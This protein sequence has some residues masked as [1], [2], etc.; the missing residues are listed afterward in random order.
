MEK[1]ATGKREGG[2]GLYGDF[3]YYDLVQHNAKISDLQYR[4]KSALL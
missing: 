3:D 4:D 1:R 2:R